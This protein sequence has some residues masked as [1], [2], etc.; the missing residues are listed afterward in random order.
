MA[1]LR[2]ASLLE[3]LVWWAHARDNSVRM[4]PP[5]CCPVLSPCI[6][7]TQKRTG[8]RP[9]NTWRQLFCFPPAP[10][11]SAGAQDQGSWQ[12][13]ELQPFPN[14]PWREQQKPRGLKVDTVKSHR[15][16]HQSQLM[17]KSLTN[18]LSSRLLWRRN[19]PESRPSRG[20]R[21]QVPLCPS[22]CPFQTLCALLVKRM[23]RMD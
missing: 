6:S 3:G 19:G 18:R 5:G 4:L 2:D 17:Q 21:W 8:K 11:A 23:N 15:S 12:R 9:R 14:L 16:A 20:P 10:S 7:T 1:P 13:P 22:L